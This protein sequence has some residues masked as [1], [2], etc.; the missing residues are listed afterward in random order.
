MKS[1]IYL[2]Y[3]FMLTAQTPS[4]RQI[5]ILVLI[6]LIVVSC[7][8]L[9]CFTYMTVESIMVGANPALAG[10]ELRLNSGKTP[11]P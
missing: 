10:L 8:T 7:Q 2:N 11:R 4:A 5:F 3:N 6:Y 9:E 1:Q